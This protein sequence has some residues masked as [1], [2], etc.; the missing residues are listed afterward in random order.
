MSTHSLSEKPLGKAKELAP[1]PLERVPT[2]GDY[3]GLP[4]HTQRDS[5]G[6][7]E[8]KVA[9]SLSAKAAWQRF[10]GHGRKRIGFFESVKAVVLSSC[11]FIS[12]VFDC[13]EFIPDP[14]LER[15]VCI[16]SIRLGF[17]LQ[18]LG[19]K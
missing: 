17:P 15:V 8:P 5:S 11:T 9:S 19:R 6:D 12:I 7:V 16:P 10:N 13:L 3:Y 14:R 2:N 4:T 1:V 18:R